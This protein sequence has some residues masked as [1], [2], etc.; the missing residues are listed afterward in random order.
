MLSGR[1]DAPGAWA[2]VKKVWR[3]SPLI[4]EEARAALRR[5][6]DEPVIQQLFVNRG[7]A[8]ESDAMAFVQR[9]QLAAGDVMLLPDMPAAVERIV[10]AIERRDRIVIYGDYDV[11]GVT[12]TALLVL[13]LQQYGAD[14]HPYIPRRDLEGYGL[15]NPALEEIAADGTALVISVDCG[16]RS[17]AEADRARELGMDLIITDHHSVGGTLPAA[18]AVINPKRPDHPYPER[19]L[20]GV[21]L[22]YKLAQALQQRLPLAASATQCESLLDLVALGSVADLAPLSGENRALVWRGLQRIS[23][24]PR[25]GIAALLVAARRRGSAVDAGTIAFQLGPRLNAAGRLDTALDAYQLLITTDAAEAQR[26]A[27]ALETLNRDRQ[28]QTTEITQRALQQALA[29]GPEQLILFAVDESFNSGIVGLAAARVQ[30]QAYRPVLVAQREPDQIRGSAR[31]IAEFHITEALDACAD[32]L[33]RYGGHAVAAGFTLL[34]HNWDA[35][36][37]RMRAIAQSK[38]GGLTLRPQLRVDAEVSVAD[39]T[40]RLARQMEFFEPTGY[41]NPAPVFAARNV[42]VASVRR[43]GTDGQHLKLQLR[44]AGS[45]SVEAVAFGEGAAAESMPKQ[46]DVAFNLELNEW[47]GRRSV[48]L[49]LRDWQPAT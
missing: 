42:N 14:V 2:A 35:F 13:H 26:L 16:V 18:I 38:L 34:P 3:I 23:Q 28:Q 37:Q 49:R 20:S 33:V 31:S 45:A 32:L 6:Q 43:M 15:N 19:N 47:Q 12:A 29:G 44:H 8:A 27:Q 36:V 46:I 22:A 5:W 11:D 1:S 30:D 48:Q 10:A 21:G 4:T 40:G 25:A 9:S 39:L 7:L 41:G 17:L 24:H